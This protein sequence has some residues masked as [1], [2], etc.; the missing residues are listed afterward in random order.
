LLYNYRYLNFK[1]SIIINSDQTLQEQ[2][3]LFYKEHSPATFEEAVEKFAIFGGVGWGK[4]DTTKPA[5]ELIKDLILSDYRYIRTD[6]GELTGGAPLYHAVLSGIALGDGKTHSAFKRAG[7]D[8]DAGERIVEELVERGIIRVAKANNTFTSWSENESV[9]NKL[10][11]TTPFLRFWFAFVSPI[12]KGIR[13]GDYKEIEER[14]ANRESEFYNLLFSELSQALL[15]VAFKEDT[16]ESIGSYWDR[17]HSFDLYGRTK[18]GKTIVGVTKYVNAKVKKSTLTQ[19]QTEAEK[20]GIKADIFVIVAKKGFSNE[21][22]SMKGESLKL[23]TL[24]NFKSLV[25]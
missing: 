6:V 4:V 25:E 20:A 14:F 22:K 12:F 11:F 1:G 10:F 24:K 7:T 17:E 23:F 9:D 16:L 8:K 2:F 19:L 13:D 18:S 3:A 5:I 21:L 15:Q